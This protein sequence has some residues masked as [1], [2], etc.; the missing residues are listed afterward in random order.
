ME[1]PPHTKQIYKTPEFRS[2][3]CRI[4]LGFLSGLNVSQ[5]TLPLGWL[6]LEGCV[7]SVGG[8]GQGTD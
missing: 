6:K 5:A 3:D 4:S 7:D 8:L 1:R 2:G